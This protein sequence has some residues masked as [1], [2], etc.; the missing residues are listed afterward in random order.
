VDDRE[1]ACIVDLFQPGEA[2][3]QR[4]FIGQL[5]QVRFETEGWT[6]FVIMVVG[7]RHDSIESVIPTGELKDDEDGVVLAGRGLALGGRFGVQRVESVGQKGGNRPGNR[8]A[9]DGSAEEFAPGS[10]K[11]FV[12]RIH[13]S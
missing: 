13:P 1:L 9:K 8:P 12:H 6:R 5:E 3:V 2:W 10:K 7:N 4:E 11:Q